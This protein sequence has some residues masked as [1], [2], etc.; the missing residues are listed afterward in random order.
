MRTLTLIL[1]LAAVLSFFL[2][3]VQEGIRSAFGRE[4]RL[5]WAVPVV[6]T[7]AFAGAAALAGA[8]S[9]TLLLVVLLYTTA[10]VACAAWQGAGSVKRPSIL[11]FAI[12]LLLWLPLEFGAG[13]ALVPAP[14]RGYLHSVAYGMAILLGLVLFGSFRM[15]PDL[16]FNLPR[17]PADW[18]LPAAAFAVAAPVLMM[19]GIG[20]GFIPWPHL[21]EKSAGAMAAAV[22]IIFAGTALP[23]EI[24]FRSMI[25]NLL[26]LRFGAGV[27][28][29]LAASFIFGCA[30]L[31]NGP[32][33]LPNWRYMILATIAGIAYGWV[34]QRAS[35]LFSSAA[36]HMLVDWTK[37]F[38]F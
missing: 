38:F 37:H 27:R 9:T 12:I 29:L 14:A 26:M 4:P 7:A 25:Q 15:F 22:G 33:A 30:H 2:S 1:M 10:P 16:K 36:L 35:T 24:L 5:I 6:L 13:G 19:V 21:P 11:D 8:W 28:T 3:R 23:E 20:V 34:F 18:W 31:D 32:Q 17:Q